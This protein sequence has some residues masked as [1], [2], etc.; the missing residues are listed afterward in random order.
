VF[1]EI[2]APFV[3]LLLPEAELDRGVD[4]VQR[5]ITLGE[6]PHIAIPSQEGEKVP[7]LK[8][9]A[10]E[11][12]NPK[13][14]FTADEK[15]NKMTREDLEALII[16]YPLPK[17]WIGRVPELQEP[18]NY[19]L[20]WETCIYEEKVWS[21]YRLPLHPFAFKMFDHYHMALDQLVPN[22]WKKLAGVANCPG[23]YYIH[24]RQRLL[25]GGPKSNNGWHSRYFFAG[26]KDQ[27]KLLLKK[28][29]NAYCKDSENKNKP[30]PDTLTKHILSHIKLRGGLSIDEPLT[31][32]QLK[33]GKIIPHKPI[34]AG[35]PVNPPP[36]LPLTHLP[37]KLHH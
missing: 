9:K 15:Q 22:G 2:E 19:G 14:W 33:Y 25:K 35:L 36:R 28:T 11:K 30:L 18:A 32:Q 26:R 1:A 31:E 6:Q 21:G 8:D 27:G 5:I 13:P 20:N 10:E 23:W 17:G 34:L 16:E 37:Q 24:I 12:E 4:H 3:Y 29:W 7:R